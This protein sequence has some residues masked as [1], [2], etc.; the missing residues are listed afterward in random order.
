MSYEVLARKLRPSG[1]AALVGQDHVV[2]ALS[3]ALDHGR[4]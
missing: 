3:H 1:F 2:R 4:L